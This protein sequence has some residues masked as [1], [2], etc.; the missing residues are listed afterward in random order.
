MFLIVVVHHVAA[1]IAYNVLDDTLVSQGKLVGICG[2][3]R[4]LT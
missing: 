4:Q 3:V 2:Q 1:I